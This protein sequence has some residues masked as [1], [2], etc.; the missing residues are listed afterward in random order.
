VAAQQSAPSP[1]S[2]F[3]GSYAVSLH[4]SAPAAVQNFAGQFNTDVNG[5]LTAGSLDIGTF[6]GSPVA[7]EALTGTL[8]MSAN[9][10]GTL[11]LNPAADNRNF[12]VYA[13]GPTLLF[14]VGVDAGR[15]AAGSLAKQY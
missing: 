5:N 10:R 2:N 14:A 1:Q 15:F 4:G 3:A 7:G 8:M 12:A 13:A 9:G 11:I 6:P